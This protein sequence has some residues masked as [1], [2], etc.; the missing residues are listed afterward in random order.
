MPHQRRP[1]RGPAPLNFYQG[2][3][4]GVGTPEVLVI[5]AVGYFLL[6]PEELYRLS[7]EIGKIVGQAREYVTKSAAE[8]QATLDGET[9]EFK[10]VRSRRPAVSRHR[11]ASSPGEQAVGGL[12]FDSEA[13][14][15]GVVPAQAW[16]K[17]RSPC[18]IATTLLDVEGTRNS[19]ERLK[20]ILMLYRLAQAMPR[21]GPKPIRRSDRYMANRARPASRRK[22]SWTRAGSTGTT[23]RWPW[24]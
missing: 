22:A 13:I 24:L 19:A 14:R 17:E 6:G 4:L 1:A 15:D 11:R 2:G 7:K 10:E 3:V 9:F 5:A 16:S 12:F 8:W 23:P 18:A 20:K 21:H